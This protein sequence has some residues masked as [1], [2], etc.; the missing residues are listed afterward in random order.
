MDMCVVDITSLTNPCITRS[1]GK[2]AALKLA[3][4]IDNCHVAIDLRN[5]ELVSLSYLDE[6]IC[7]YL[8]SVNKGNIIFISNKNIDSKLSKIAAVRSV[9]IHCCNSRNKEY[10]VPA[11]CYLPPTPIFDVSKS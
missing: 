2:E 6:L 8:D 7:Y 10:V 1:R 4:Y 3:S 5:A 11:E 9:N